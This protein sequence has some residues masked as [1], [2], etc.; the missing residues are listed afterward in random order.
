MINFF[1]ERTLGRRSLIILVCE[2][3]FIIII[4]R[5][6]AW[7]L[8]LSELKLNTLLEILQRLFIVEA[9]TMRRGVP[10]HALMVQGSS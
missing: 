7:V 1:R 2:A 8:R 5:G 10:P 4:V 9:D 6:E 3:I